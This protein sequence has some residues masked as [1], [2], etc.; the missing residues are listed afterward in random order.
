M[1]DICLSWGNSDR[2]EIPSPVGLIANSNSANR[3][4]GPLPEKEPFNPAPPHP[5]A[6]KIS[7]GQNLAWLVIAAI[8]A[9]EDTRLNG[10][11]SSRS[12]HGEPDPGQENTSQ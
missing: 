4:E 11:A 5:P 2:S 9:T 7:P 8:I 6:I 3:T 10:A 12:G 1:P